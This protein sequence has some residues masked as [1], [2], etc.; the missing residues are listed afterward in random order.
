MCNLLYSSPLFVDNLSGASNMKIELH[1]GERW[2][3]DARSSASKSFS[4]SVDF[5]SWNEISAIT[6]NE[7]GCEGGEIIGETGLSPK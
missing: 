7:E 1:T 6:K 5:P 2:V 3:Q 4:S